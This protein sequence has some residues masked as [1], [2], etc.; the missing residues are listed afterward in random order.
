MEMVIHKQRTNT[1]LLATRVVVVLLKAIG[2]KKIRDA[3]IVLTQYEDVNIQSQ[4]AR[5][6]EINLTNQEV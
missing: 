6:F 1:P 4:A 5:N 2:E 3:T